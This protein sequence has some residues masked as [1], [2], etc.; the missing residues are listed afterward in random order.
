[1][2]LSELLC[3]KQVALMVV[4]MA[5]QQRETPALLE[6]QLLCPRLRPEEDEANNKRHHACSSS[7]SLAKKG[8][9]TAVGVVWGTA[10]AGSAAVCAGDDVL[11]VW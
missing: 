5:Q 4:A 2:P 7:Q 9:P 6:G 3:S 11:A 8:G 1:M 10:A